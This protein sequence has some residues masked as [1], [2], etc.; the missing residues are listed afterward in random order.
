[1]SGALD[2]LRCCARLRRLTV[3]RDISQLVGWRALRERRL[4]AADPNPRLVLSA[5]AGTDEVSRFSS[6]RPGV[7][8]GARFSPDVRSRVLAPLLEALALPNY[9]NKGLGEDSDR[10]E[11]VDRVVAR[12]HCPSMRHFS[13]DG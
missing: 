2:V 12:M 7:V 13:V 10:T 6:V 5:S 3:A 8:D 1:L 11:L 9:F 4:E